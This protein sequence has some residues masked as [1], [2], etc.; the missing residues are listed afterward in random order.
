V[1]IG[2]V[3]D[4]ELGNDTD[5]ACMG[6]V[7]EMAQIGHRS[8]VGMDGAIIADVVTVIEPEDG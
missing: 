8:V 3:I 7:D 1:P 5:A 6:G 2:R 4:D